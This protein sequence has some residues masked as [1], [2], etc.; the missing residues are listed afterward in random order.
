MLI[1]A[2]T[3]C[4]TGITTTPKGYTCIMHKCERFRNMNDIFLLDKLATKTSTIN[5]MLQQLRL[6]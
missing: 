3:V 4:L 2:N 1:T 5:E 6:L